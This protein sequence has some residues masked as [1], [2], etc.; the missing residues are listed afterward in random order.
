MF[1][2]E[3]GRK[4][5]KLRETPEI[6]ETVGPEGG[7][8]LRYTLERHTTTAEEAR[9]AGRGGTI[10]R[11]RQWTLLAIDNL[12]GESVEEAFSEGSKFLSVLAGVNPGR[13][14]ITLWT[15]PDSFETYRQIRRELYHRGFSAAAR[16]LPQGVPISGSPEGSKSAA[17]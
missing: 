16:P 2:A 4:V 9:A 1:Q 13:H 7:F 11:L 3:A 10:V 5:Y 12:P 14:T 17:Q 6:T 15:Y 8:R